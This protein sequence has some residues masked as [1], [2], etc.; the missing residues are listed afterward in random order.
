MKKLLTILALFVNASVFA[1]GVGSIDYIKVQENYSFAKQSV[2]E[3]E[4]QTTAL[5]QF[6]FDKE[7]QY[8]QLD[9]PLK[10]QNFEAATA[11]EYKAKE[12]ALIKL[13]SQREEQ[14]Y[15]KIQTAARQVLVEQKLDA[16][17]DIRVIFVGGV[18]V[19][20]LVINKLKLNP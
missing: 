15:N 14:V 10:K 11:K 9:T 5:K 18:D 4:N 17:V 20:E 12:E 8:N 1:G 6:M 3:I 16:I 2:K 19:T 13:K 7:K